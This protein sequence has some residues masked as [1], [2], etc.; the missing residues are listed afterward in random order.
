MPFA[1]VSHA[2]VRTVRMRCERPTKSS[3]RENVSPPS[4]RRRCESWLA[5]LEVPSR[6]TTDACAWLRFIFES[7]YATR[8]T[9]GFGARSRTTQKAAR[10]QLPW[11]SC[12][13][14][15]VW[16]SSCS[17]RTATERRGADSSE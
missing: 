12:F 15:G 17:K 11:M 4:V 9:A 5:L 7:S 13:E 6:T 16:K 10:T 8:T 14:Y 2:A 1:V 3:P